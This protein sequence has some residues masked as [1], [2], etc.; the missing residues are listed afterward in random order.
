MGFTFGNLGKQM[1]LLILIIFLWILLFAPIL[2]IL[3]LISFT[4]FDLSHSDFCL[5]K[6]LLSCV[7]MICFFILGKGLLS[8]TFKIN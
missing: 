5:A 2:K 7:Y 6:Y 1:L 4:Y 3:L 8:V